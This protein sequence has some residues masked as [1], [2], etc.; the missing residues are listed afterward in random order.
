MSR[1]SIPPKRDQRPAVIARTL[2]PTLPPPIPGQPEA[3]RVTTH[4][5][6]VEARTNAFAAGL[7]FGKL[8]PG[9]REEVI[10]ALRDV[11]SEVKRLSGS[12]SPERTAPAETRLK[13]LIRL[14]RFTAEPPS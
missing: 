1:T 3:E 9:A 2:C 7:A 13:N 8:A 4:Q 10:D 12:L 5:T 14:V 11:L 6:L